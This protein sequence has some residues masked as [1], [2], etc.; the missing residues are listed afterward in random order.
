MC[1]RGVLYTTGLVKMH[2]LKLY[3]GNIL[4]IRELFDFS[5]LTFRNLEGNMLFFTRVLRT[6]EL[7]V[8]LEAFS[9][10]IF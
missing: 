8:K 5:I 3:T 1:K 2:K 6:L 4:K 10:T 7:F 9:A